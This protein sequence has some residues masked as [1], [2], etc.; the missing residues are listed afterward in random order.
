MHASWTAAWRSATWRPASGA[1]RTRKWRPECPAFLA[2]PFNRDQCYKII[3]AL[4]DP[5]TGCYIMAI[6]CILIE[7][8][9]LGRLG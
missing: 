7:L 2:V 6:L 8:A 5:P 4:T 9:I 3:F 1:P